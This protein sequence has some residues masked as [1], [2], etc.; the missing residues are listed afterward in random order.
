MLLVSILVSTFILTLGIWGWIRQKNFH[1]GDKKSWDWKFRQACYDDENI[2][3]VLNSIGG[4]L[5]V[6]SLIA[7]LAIGVKYSQIRVIDDRISLYQEENTKIEEQVNIIVEKY[8]AYEKDTFENCKIEDPTMVFVMY[9]KLK[10]D[11]LVT[12][13]INL[14]VENNKQIKKLKSEKLDYHLMAWWLYFG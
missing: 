7:T 1:V 2:Y 4:I 12:K 5:L 6:I 14:Y 3:S 13:Q 10:S 9:P 11:S 8:Q